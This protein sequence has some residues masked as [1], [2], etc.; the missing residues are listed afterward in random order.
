[1]GK[2]VQH[3]SNGNLLIKFWVRSRLLFHYETFDFHFYFIFRYYFEWFGY[4][5]FM[6]VYE[7]SI[8]YKVH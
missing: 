7:I 4:I 3:K 1:M 5:N 6:F 8:N 2:N